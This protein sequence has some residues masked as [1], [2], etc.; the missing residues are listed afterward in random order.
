MIPVGDSFRID[1]GPLSVDPFLTIEASL[2][3]KVH[4]VIVWDKVTEV[5]KAI[6][7]HE[8]TPLHV[9]NIEEVAGAKV[10]FRGHVEAEVELKAFGLEERLEVIA[11]DGRNRVVAGLN[12][13]TTMSSGRSRTVAPEKGRPP[14]SES[15]CKNE[16]DSLESRGGTDCQTC[17]TMASQ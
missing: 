15:G 5:D 1:A 8:A 7:A 14:Q 9:K 10:I 2:V 16:V 4:T 6:S 11:F 17:A 3:M 12:A 13:A